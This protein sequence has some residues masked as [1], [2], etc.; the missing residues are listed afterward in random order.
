M[1]PKI[2]REV[3][4]GELRSQGCQPKE[5]HNGN[6]G[7]WWLPPWGGPKF[8]LQWDKADPSHVD[9]QQLRCILG[10]LAMYRPLNK[11]QH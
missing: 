10:D 7:Q 8:F 5:I 6:L 3:A 11:P 1:P 4:E 9:E 2:L